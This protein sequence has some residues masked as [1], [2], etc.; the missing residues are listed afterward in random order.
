MKNWIKEYLRHLEIE[1]GV[2]PHTLRAYATDLEQLRVYLESDHQEM[3][4]ASFSGKNALSCVGGSLLDRL[5]TP[6]LRAYLRQTGRKASAATASRKL[7]SVRG[8]LRF[9]GHRGMLESNPLLN[10]KGAKRRQSLPRHLTVDDTYRL[11]DAPS[12]GKLLRARDR[13]LLETLYSTGIRVSELVGLNQDSLDPE[14]GIV[15]IWGKGRKERIVPIGER[16]IK[17]IQEYR[18]RVVPLG[19]SRELPKALF[20]NARGGQLTARSAA[21]ILEAWR[22]RA[23]ID[24]KVSPHALR[25]SFATH[26]L[27]AGADLRS[28]QELLGHQSLST[29]QRYMHVQLADLM[30][31]YDRAHPRA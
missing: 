4:P 16:A 10:V 30:A 8:F 1:R 6:V 11:L 23:G 27:N 15:R 12:D 19:G 28:I 25:H 20:L 17:L 13:A 26:L 5:T 3:D 2:S 9:L 21:R 14:L 7:S 24:K 18:Q 22:K 31:V 29:T